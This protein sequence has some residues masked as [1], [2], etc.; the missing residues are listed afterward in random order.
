MAEE[1]H[2]VGETKIIILANSIF[3]SISNER[4]LK[5]KVLARRWPFL[6]VSYTPNGISCLEIGAHIPGAPF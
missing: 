3:S 5:P 2:H 4:L 1:Y 6:G